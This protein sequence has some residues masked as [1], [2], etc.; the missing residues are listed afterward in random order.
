MNEFSTVVWEREA[1]KWD[2]VPEV[3]EWCPDDIADVVFDGES[4]VNDDTKA[5]HWAGGSDIVTI[6]EEREVLGRW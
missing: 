3:E 6:D 4:G 5:K 1:W 2:D